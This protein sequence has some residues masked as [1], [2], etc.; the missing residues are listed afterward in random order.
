MGCR[1]A[2][3]LG[4]ACVKMPFAIGGSG[5][6]YIYGHVDA[7]YRPDMSKDECVEFVTKGA[8][9]CVWLLAVAGW[10]LRAPSQTPLAEVQQKGLSPPTQHTRSSPVPACPMQPFRMPWP[11]M[12]P[13]EATFAW[14]SLTRLALSAGACGAGILG[15]GVGRHR[16]HSRDPIHPPPPPCGRCRHPQVHSRRRVTVSAALNSAVVRMDRAP[17]LADSPL[18]HKFMKRGVRPPSSRLPWR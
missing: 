7:T 9:L 17:G 18:Q 11:A 8:C 5:S 1:Y 3:P 15:C 4:G 2:I 12:A 14:S 10:L 6:T 13:L 16:E